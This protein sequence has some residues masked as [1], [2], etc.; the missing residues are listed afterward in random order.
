M[1]SYLH[2]I[3]YILSGTKKKLIFLVGIF[4]LSSLLEAIGIGLIAPFLKIAANPELIHKI[5]LL[6][7][8]Y[9]SLKLET[10][11]QFIPIMGLLMIAVFSIKSTLYFLGKAYTVNFSFNQKKRLISRLM[12][13]YLKVPYTFHLSRNSAT[14][15]KN[16]VMETNQFT[17]YCLLPSLNA[18]A[19]LIVL[20]VLLLLLAKTKLLLLAMT[21]G[22]LLPTFI[23]FNKLGKK[24]RR[25]GEI[26][27]KS[28]KEMIRILNHG[29]GG[30]KETRIIGCESYFEQQM[31]DEASK[32]AKAATLFQSL[33]LL[34]KVVIENTLIILL[35]L[36]ISIS[37][38]Y[39]KDSVQE[40]TA[41]LGVF[42]IASVRLISSATVVI[43]SLGHM[44]NT[45]YILNMLY[46]DLKEIEKEK[47]NDLKTKRYFGTRTNS[48]IVS[49]GKSQLID[50]NKIVELKDVTYKYPGIEEPAI[51]K[52]SLKIEKGQSVALIGK[53]GAGKTTLA[54]IILGLL[55]P[56]SGDILV[57]GVSIYTNLRSWQ[58]SIGYIPQSIF[59]IDDT[60]ERNIAFGVPDKKIDKARLRNAIEAAQ[61]TELIE[62]L[63]DKIK[64]EVGER[65][66]RLSGGQRQR[67]GIA[68]SLYHERE[69]LVL[70]EAT[71]ALDNETESLVSEAIRNLVGA[72]TLIIIAHRLSTVEHCDRVYLLEK[73][74]LVRSGSYQEVVEQNN[75]SKNSLL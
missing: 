47:A 22:I 37:Q 50:F 18:T 75:Y 71:S 34:P 42:A 51:Q 52:V 31:E 2:K 67:I 6:N 74:H 44:R 63:P 27:S 61:L 72:K 21:L 3:L 65:G 35:V 41:V 11:N 25:W 26:K 43:Q 53:S 10:S 56:Q 16:T 30:I 49:N 38:I 14:I 7:S 45:S 8:I 28:Q 55:E 5:P 58:N 60:I 59:L 68:R 17:Q 66:I 64:T 23:L 19:S 62:Q 73:G 24:F 40:L 12:N 33:Q 13:G 48:K 32:F 1:F 29:M 69:I 9:L 70:D 46:F 20:V 57:D 36:F 4:I 54:D 15:I 39:L